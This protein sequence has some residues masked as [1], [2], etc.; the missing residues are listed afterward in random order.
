M[1]SGSQQQSS[2]GN[3]KPNGAMPATS[4][5]FW[6][7]ATDHDDKL[8][9]AQV[10]ALAKQ[11]ID[12]KLGWLGAQSRL[13]DWIDAAGL[14]SFCAGNGRRRAEARQLLFPIRR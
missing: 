10:S 14:P 8:D 4:A 7:K 11:V 5:T 13:D 3:G 12:N 9:R 1:A 6:L 2:K